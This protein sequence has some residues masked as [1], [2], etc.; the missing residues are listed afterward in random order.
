M[1]NL[2]E[3]CPITRYNKFF[4]G[5][6]LIFSTFFS[7]YQR[8][9][10]FCF[11]MY[12]F[13]GQLVSSFSPSLRSAKYGD[14]FFETIW[15]CRG[16]VPFMPYHWKR[17]NQAFRILKINLPEKSSPLFFEK[18]IL[19]LTKE[20]GGHRVRLSVWRK[21]AGL[22]TPKTN[23][24]V[25]LIESTPLTAGEFVLN[26][27]GLRI[28]IYRENKLPLARGAS[29]QKYLLANIKSCNSLPFILANIYRKENNLDDVLLLNSSGRIACG[30]SSN[31]FLWEKNRL[32]TPALSE[33]CVAGTMR[34]VVV[35]ICAKK[36]IDVVE[37]PVF[38]KDLKNAEGIFLT[39]AIAGLRWV[40]SIVGIK[41]E[42][43]G[44]LPEELLESLKII[45]AGGLLRSLK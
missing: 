12:N 17:M 9:V 15:V 40:E 8:A 4:T 32:I 25:F 5:P 20:N 1:Q 37:K 16:K 3:A 29:D 6:A 19:K 13:N 31:I 27:R 14:G 43:P 36:S 34:N 39:N 21:G 2:F 33:G 22:Y 30:G 26:K 38:Q 44:G 35:D 41:K 10:Y 7:I 45:G 42:Y 23:E 11:G 28:G 18:E 24:P